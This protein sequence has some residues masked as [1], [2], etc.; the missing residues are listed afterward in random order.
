M[1]ILTRQKNESITIG[2]GL[3]MVEVRVVDIRGDKIR[4]GITAPLDMPV[5][6][7]EIYDAIQRAKQR[8]KGQDNG[9]KE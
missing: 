7:R 4:L 3:D 9:A 1:L 8:E 2:D 5:H 6:R